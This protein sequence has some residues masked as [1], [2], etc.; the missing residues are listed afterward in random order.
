M[1]IDIDEAINLIQ[2]D[3]DDEDVDWNSPLGRAYKLS[4]EALKRIKLGRDTPAG[5]SFI[6]LP[7]ETI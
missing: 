1:T 3:I 2:E 6:P 4:F 7:G 5:L